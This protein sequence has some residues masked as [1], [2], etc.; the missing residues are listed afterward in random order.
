VNADASEAPF[1]NTH[2]DALADR[3]SGPLALRTLV[4]LVAQDLVPDGERYRP[5]QA[6]WLLLAA[7]LFFQACFPLSWA[8][9]AVKDSRRHAA[10][11]SF[12]Q[13][14]YWVDSYRVLFFGF[15]GRYLDRADGQKQATQTLY[16]WNVA[17]GALEERG[18][19]AAALCFA[20]GYVRYPRWNLKEGPPNEK[21][22]ILAGELGKERVIADVIQ[23]PDELDR[24]TC[25]RKSVENLPDWT[26]GQAVLRLKPEH[27]FL[28]LGPLKQ[29]GNTPVTYHPK[30][31]R[32]GIVMPFNRREAK[33]AFIEYVPFRNAYLITGDYFVSDALHPQGGYNRTP[34]PK[35]VRIPL[36]WLHPDGQVSEIKL[37]TE[38]RFGVRIFAMR[39]GLFFISHASTVGMDGLF[40]VSEAGV[41][42]VLKGFIDA[43]AVSP[44]GCRL[45][46]D[47]GGNF[48]ER[49]ERRTLKALDVCKGG[50]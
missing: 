32:N 24:E 21:V 29:D 18:D 15:N 50:N 26:H 40:A 25:K 11:N 27:G 37:P 22:E 16:L 31:E 43:Y 6:R 42:R 13:T 46:M 49:E 34:W 45:A 9:Y 28:V 7:L 41:S 1:L 14:I 36:W 12:A 48:D 17:N 35:G 38:A 3:P 44:D 5:K 23:P 2:S 33:L 4:E 47:H 8:E 10:S 19:I 20:N 39:N 30:G